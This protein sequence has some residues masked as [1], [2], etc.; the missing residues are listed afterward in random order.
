MRRTR[1]SRS[2]SPNATGSGSISVAPRSTWTSRA[3]TTR[4]CTGRAART[5][6]SSRRPIATTTR[7]SKATS[8][9]SPTSRSPRR[10]S[11]S[12][13]L[14]RAVRPARTV[15]RRPHVQGRSPAARPA[16]PVDLRNLPLE[17]R[18]RVLQ[19]RAVGLRFA[20]PRGML[21]KLPPAIG[22]ALRRGRPGMNRIAANRD[23]LGGS[24]E[25]LLLESPAF[26]KDTT[27]PVRFTAD[28]E[29]VS[30]PLRWSQ[31]PEGT[32][33]LA[34]LVEAAD[35]PTPAPLVHALVANLTRTGE[36]L[37]GAIREGVERATGLLIGKHSI[38]NASWLP[39]H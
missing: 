19:R 5:R 12:T 6:S 10:R 16:R 27:I 33:S 30:P 37:E 35:S 31:L 39:P 17:P 1:S 38:F 13:R 23:D 11:R 34:L 26:A 15:A 7:S 36:L 14:R 3:R 18:G 9:A 2:G 22:R 25:A 21:E 28:G 8:A 24:N 32:V 4:R 20:S 29:G